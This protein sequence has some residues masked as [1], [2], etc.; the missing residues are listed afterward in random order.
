M[1]ILQTGKPR[2]RGGKHAQLGRGR[3]E[4]KPRQPGCRVCNTSPPPLQVPRSPG[5]QPIHLR[6]EVLVYEDVIAVQLKAVLVTDDHL[7]HALQASDKDVVHVAEKRLYCLGPVLGRQV[8][9]EAL[10][11]PLA[12]LSPATRLGEETSISSDLANQ[13][14]HSPSAQTLVL[15]KGSPALTPVMSRTLTG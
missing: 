12:A 9:P 3:A 7:L 13:D 8:L 14:G 2:L 4:L 15:D 10:Q 5:H 1:T 6:L 11:H